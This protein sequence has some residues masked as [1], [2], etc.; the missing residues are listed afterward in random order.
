MVFY[1]IHICRFKTKQKT[2]KVEIK[3][4]S[5]DKTGMFAERMY[6]NPTF[7]AV[8]ICTFHTDFLTG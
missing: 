5:D 4:S 8:K 3:V 6:H 1:V 7:G 2:D